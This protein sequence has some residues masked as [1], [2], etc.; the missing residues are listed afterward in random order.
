[1]M[2][3]NGG[4]GWSLVASHL[5]RAM[6]GRKR[7]MAGKRERERERER[8]RGREGERGGYSH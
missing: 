3:A 6:M 4:V 5:K 2:M 7:K 8:E 1:M